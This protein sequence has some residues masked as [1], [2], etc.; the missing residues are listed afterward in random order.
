MTNE[1]RQRS[2]SNE[3][4]ENGKTVE[5]PKPSYWD[6]L[7][8]G[9]KWIERYSEPLEKFFER[10]PEFISTFIATLAV[11]TFGSTLRGENLSFFFAIDIHF[12]DIVDETMIISL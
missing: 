6:P 12:T 7:T 3:V 9:V 4:H 1:V 2:Q 11:F 10:L 8:E 5:E